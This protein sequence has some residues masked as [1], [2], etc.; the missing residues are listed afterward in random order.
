MARRSPSSHDLA[1]ARAFARALAE[2]HDPAV[3]DVT[4]FGSRARG[5]GDEESDLDLFVALHRDDPRG[6]VEATALRLAC[7]LTLEHG[8]LVSV[9]V[10]DRAF[11]AS[12]EGYSLLETLKEEGIRL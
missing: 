11:L 2:H 8:V 7:D 9:L 1:I 12:H 4:L 6:E 5:E 10:A 3:F